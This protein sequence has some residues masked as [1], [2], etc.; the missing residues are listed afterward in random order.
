M[1]SRSVRS[2]TAVTVMLMSWL[3][4]VEAQEQRDGLFSAVNPAA[5]QPDSPK[6]TS[7]DAMTVRHRMVTMD[8]GRLRRAQASASAFPRRPARI[9][10]V[11]PRTSGRD[12]VSESDAIL[13]LNLF[14]DV[15]VTGVVEQTAPTFS[16][17]YSLSGR[18]VGKPHGTLTLVVNGKTVAGTV[19]TLRGTYR[20]RSMGGRRYAISEVEEPPLKCRVGEP[21]SETDHRH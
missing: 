19:R 17:G 13:T 7:H 21:D 3:L 18:L 9:K 1:S 2:V 8:L 12:A 10:A 14:D 11:S 5:A 20:I 16:G 4:T 15:L 6:P